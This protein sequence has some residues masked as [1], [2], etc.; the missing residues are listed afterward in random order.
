MSYQIYKYKYKTSSTFDADTTVEWLNQVI[1]PYKE[2]LESE[3]LLIILDR[4]TCHVSTK[5]INID[6]F[7]HYFKLIYFI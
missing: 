1:L 7:I 2:Q 4:V 6:L 3:R 5:V